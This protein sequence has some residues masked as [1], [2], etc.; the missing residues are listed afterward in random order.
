MSYT[1]T[2]YIELGDTEYELSVDYEPATEP[3]RD[4]PGSGPEVYQHPIVR[5]SNGSG[6]EVMRLESF[7]LDYAAA[8]C[9]DLREAERCLDDECAYKAQANLEAEYDSRRDLY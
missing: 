8:R 9:M 3:G 7:L 2:V 4:D 1:T 6:W 5:Y